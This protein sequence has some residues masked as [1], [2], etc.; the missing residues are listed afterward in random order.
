M[1]IN[2]QYPV[3]VKTVVDG[4]TLKLDM[5]LGFGIWKLNQSFR[6]V[7]TDA[8][9]IHSDNPLEVQAGLAV[10]SFV[11]TL[12]CPEACKPAIKTMVESHELD[13][14][15]RV[16]GEIY[17]P[18]GEALSRLLLDMKAVKAYSGAKKP[19]WTTDELNAVLQ[20]VMFMTT[21]MLKSELQEVKK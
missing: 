2:Y 19:L 8:P 17:T 15:G 1:K 7:A 12:M 14:Y 3:V 18:R 6:L 4:D 21:A 9:E 10:K 5:D 13:K 11:T 16:L 20:S